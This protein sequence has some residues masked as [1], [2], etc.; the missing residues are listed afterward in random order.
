MKR[1]ITMALAVVLSVTF[2]FTACASNTVS[3]S[4]DTETPATSTSST[5]GSTNGAPA[6]LT[7]L[8][9]QSRSVIG[10]SAFATGFFTALDKF[11]DENPNIKV[12]YEELDQTA[13]QTKI[14]ALGASD[15]M[16]DLFMLKGSWVSNFVDNG[17]VSD[18]T[19]ELNADSTWKDS[20]IK[21]GFDSIT[22]DGKVYGI[23]QE[24]MTTSLVFYNSK[25]WADIGYN[26]FPTTWSEL[27]KAVEKFKA[28]GITAFVMGNK[29]NWP[30]ESCWLSTLG[31]RFT[32]TEWTNSIINNKGA[33]FTDPDFVNALKTF[34]D[35][36]KAGA[37]NVNINS[38]DDIE[39]NSV[40]FNKK[41]AAIVNGSWFISDMSSAPKDVNDDTKLAILPAVEGGKGDPMTA[42]G[43]PAWFLS[44]SN[45]VTDANRQAAISLLKNLTDNR[46]A[47]VTASMGGVTAWAKPTYDTT[48]VPALY[49]QYNEL[50]QNV[51]AVPI[52]DATMESAVI[53]A[54]N[55]GLQE[56][57]INKKTPEQLASEIQREQDIVNAK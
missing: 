18:V 6:E 39:Q 44:L 26:E 11:I 28:K 7:M 14:T 42:S 41:A 49:N 15:D 33:K 45:K 56:L 31:D 4:T 22:R 5:A 12:T 9:H 17:W 21:G 54:M 1:K 2:L 37:F 36:A 19:T 47:D 34:Q 40:Y 35:F 43:G 50:M 52:Y 20:Y 51:T 32:G 55:V 13:Y 53:E 46:Q 16:P 38:I 27:T 30:A 10:Q 48:K 29:A 23:P 57:L 3:P 24:S 8:V 25:M